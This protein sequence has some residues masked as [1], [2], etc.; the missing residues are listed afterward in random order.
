LIV[1]EIKLV[2][3]LLIAFVL[4]FLTMSHRLLMIMIAKQIALLFVLLVVYLFYPFF[5]GILSSGRKEYLEN[6]IF[7][8]V[9][10]LSLVPV[11]NHLAMVHNHH[12]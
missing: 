4:A 11:R 2:F 3:S 1:I 10:Y 6:I 12:G 8:L 9:R 5:Q 7:L